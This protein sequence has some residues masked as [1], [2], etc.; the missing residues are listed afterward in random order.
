MGTFGNINSS[1]LSI[2]RR[3]DSSTQ[4]LSE[5]EGS[6][7]DVDSQHAVAALV[8]FRR[9]PK[10]GGLV[11][12]V[13]LSQRFEHSVLELVPVESVCRFGRHLDGDLASEVC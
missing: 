13:C 7:K 9:C 5:A 12:K 6:C 11:D 2:V 3:S 1:S 8:C 10:I 4:R